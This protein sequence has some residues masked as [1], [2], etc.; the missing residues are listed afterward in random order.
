MVQNRSPMA[1]YFFIFLANQKYKDWKIQEEKTM[2]KLLWTSA[3]ALTAV[4]CLTACDDS[5][6][7][8]SN[9]VPSY[10]TEAALPDT[11]EMEVA[12]AGD[13]YF[14]CFENKWIEVT[15]SATVEKI[16]EGLDEKE[17][18]EQLEELEEKLEEAAAATKK[19][20]SSK[21][22]ASSA[23][24]DEGD[25]TPESSASEEECTGR[26]CGTGNSSSSKKS[27]GGSGNGGS[28]SGD[29]GSGSGSGSSSDS[30][31]GS[32]DSDEESSSSDKSSSS[33]KNSSSSVNN[34]S[35]SKGNSSSSVAA[36]SSSED[37]C[38]GKSLTSSQFCDSRDGQIYKKVTI[39]TQIWMA[40]NL[41]YVTSSG[42]SCLND[43]PSNCTTLGRLYEWQVANDVA[44]PDGWHLPSYNEF[45][46]LNG[47]FESPTAKHLKANSDLWP[48]DQNGDDTR[49]FAGLPGGIYVSTTKKYSDYTDHAYFWAATKLV[50]EPYYFI[51]HRSGEDGYFYHNNPK[52]QVSVRCVKD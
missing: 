14:A 9:S 29:S 50:D 22:V 37:K 18:K 36:S 3:M 48:S 5:S 21:K 45:T 27:S 51:L 15:D 28:G 11:C 49:G 43:E 38:K 41:N 1:A 6:S 35:S 34:S 12:K 8:A 47:A 4:A 26:R 2:K 13:T 31:V 23:D 40:Q 19:S 30:G 42:S 17:L 25:V 44:C 52:H 24:A 10:K 7:G 46:T 32:S 39:G 20:S 33:V 16:K